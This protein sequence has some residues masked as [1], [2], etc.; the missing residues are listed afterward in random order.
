MTISKQVSRQLGNAVQEFA[1]LVL[2]TIEPADVPKEHAEAAARSRRGDPEQVPGSRHFATVLAYGSF[3]MENGPTIECEA[4]PG[5]SGVITLT[6]VTKLSSGQPQVQLK[7]ILTH[8]RFDDPSVRIEQ[9]YARESTGT[10][11]GT[12]E[13]ERAALL[14]GRASFSQYL[15]LVLDGRPLANP[16]PLVM[17][18]DRV[19]EWPPVGSTFVSEAPIGFVDLA[20]LE[21]PEAPIVARLAACKAVTVSDLDPLLPPDMQRAMLR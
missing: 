2:R 15:I 19:E 21:D 18:A 12:L 11:T 4:I 17:T 9:H 8:F 16:E 10:L 6:D 20:R 5:L 13:G 1:E 14:P 7:R 3:E